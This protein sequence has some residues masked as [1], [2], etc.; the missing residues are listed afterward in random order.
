MKGPGS[1]TLEIYPQRITENAKTVIDLCRQHGVDVACV[2]KVVRAHHAVAR[3]LLE[4]GARSLADSR[5]ENLQLHRCN[6][7]TG[8]LLLLRLPTPS[9]AAEVVR[10]ADLS[11]VSELATMRALGAAT[12]AAHLPQHRGI[13]MVDLGDL[14]EGLWTDQ[15]IDAVR[16]ASKIEGFELAGLGCNL[17]CFGGVIPTRENMEQLV[18]LHSACRNATGLELPLLS[19][20]N[21]GGLPLLASG[22]LPKE[23]NHFRVGEAIML[24][25][26]VI[27][28]SPWP[29][30]RQ[31]TFVVNAE[32]IELQT[33]PSVPIGKRGQDAFGGFEEFVDRGR[34]RRAILDLG[35]QDAIL[36]GLSPC[37]EGVEVLGGSSDHLIVDV[38]DAPSPLDVG[39]TLRFFPDYGSLLA[40]STS[41][42]V[43]KIVV[44]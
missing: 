36:E 1:P 18:E 7:F 35:R 31:D 40:L 21:S 19:G 2:T 29:G 17:T 25:R 10:A 38:E 42:Y 30:T 14:R 12:L 22:D 39:A 23:I 32:I 37:D 34:R 9:R 28:R 13:L 16:E 4:A 3:A 44:I 6:G 15:V 33:K 8:P 24:G 27:D 26:N 11:L 20:G 5:L 41:P 43:Q